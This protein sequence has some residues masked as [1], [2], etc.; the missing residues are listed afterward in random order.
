MKKIIFS[1]SAVLF[2]TALCAQPV[3]TLI[4]MTSEGGNGLGTIFGLSPGGV[5]LTQQYNFDGNTGKKPYAG[6]IQATNGKLYGMTGDGGI[7]NQ[8]IIF[9]YDLITQTYSKKYDFIYDMGGT[10]RGKLMQA[11]NGKLY[12]MTAGGGANGQGVLFEFDIITS[13]FIN[14]ADFNSATTGSNPL[15]SLIQASNGKLY[16]LANSGGINDKGVLFEYDITSNTLILKKSFN[17]TNGSY[18]YGSLM[19]AS[20]DKLYGMTSEGGVNNLGLLFE[21]DITG[22][23][24]TTKKSFN[25]TNGSHPLGSLIQANNNKLYG[26]TFDGGVSDGGAL[27]EYDFTANIFSVKKSFDGTNGA[28]PNGSLMQAPDG[29]LY[30]MTTYGGSSDQGVILQ[31]D[32]TG[33]VLAVVAL[34]ISNG[35]GGEPVG[36][37][38]QASNGKFYGATQI[39]LFAGQG[40]VFEYNNITGDYR[41]LIVFNQAPNGSVPNASLVQASNGKLYGLTKEGGT[42]D[43]GV[44]FEYN[45]A[46]NAY[47]KKIDFNGINGA[48]PLGSL[49]Q[50]SN[51]KLYGMATYG[52]AKSVG[53]IFEYNITTNILTKK[54]DFD[55][56]VTG[57]YP[58]GALMQASNGKLYGM[59]S[60]GGMNKKGVLF[61]YDITSNTCTKKIDFNGTNLGSNPYGSLLQSTNG[62]L[63]G[64]ATLGGNSDKGT[65]FEYDA[66]NNTYA[67]KMDFDGIATGSNPE[68]SLIQSSNGKLYG[69][70]NSGGINDKGVLFEYDETN[71]VFTKKLDFDSISTGSYPGGSLILASNGKLYGMT[72]GGGVNYGGVIFEYDLSTNSY[73]KKVDF[74]G[75]NGTYPKGN[76]IEISLCQSTYSIINISNC[77]SYT[78]N[79]QTYISSGIYTQTLPNSVGCDSVITLNLT[80]NNTSSTITQIACNSYTWNGNIYSTS[81]T[82]NDTIPNAAN[83]DSIM[84]L[85]LIIKQPSSSNNIISA[86]NNY[87]WNGTTYSASGTFNKTISNKAGCDSSMTLNLTINNASS[88]TT[89]QTAC[90]SYIWN[91]TTYIS[92][93]TYNK[94]IPNKAGC[95]SVM[96]LQ[97]TIKNTYSTQT[98]SACANYTWNGKVYT[99]SNTYKDTIPNAASCDSIMT[100]NLTINNAPA[101]PSTIAGS[102]T[103]C[104]GTTNTYSITAVAG[105]TNYTWTLPSGWSG[106]ST[107][108]SIS[109]TANTTGGS[110]TVIANNACGSS[111]ARTLAVTVNSITATPGT[112]NGNASICSGTANTYSVAAVAGATDYIWTL[113]SGWTGTSTTNSISTTASATS[114]YVTVKSNNACG[115]SSSKTLTITVNAINVSV[116]Q[117]NAI[118]T[119]NAT[120][121]FYQWLDCNNGNAIISGENS[122]TFIASANGSYAV[123][124]TKSGCS[125]TSS[126][127]TVDMGS[128]G[129]ANNSVNNLTV[130]P[131]PSTGLF[132]IESNILNGKL[133]ISNLLGVIVFEKDKFQTGENIDLSRIAE[134]VYYLRIQDKENQII[135][136]IVIHK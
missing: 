89:T 52:G 99:T 132:Y 39:D 60:E 109:T 45:P 87:T 91:G 86:C 19:Q 65:L 97:L 13:T 134:G 5:N 111:S 3:P 22:N 116:T 6:V 2:C 43:V 127:Y 47:S 28:F 117:N 36:E 53:V 66:T 68:G 4:G 26:L 102:A 100:L 82:F 33:N 21:Y 118:L 119:A 136:P 70:T 120:S 24:L 32:I 42:N 80:I 107:T 92:T 84:T 27:F 75:Q 93:G 62:K 57:S 105:A 1:I 18:P 10:P 72:I 56:T 51:G 59:T 114:G 126:C 69:L 37:L 48:Y 41:N 15:G 121:D 110:I 23:I 58:L 104:S 8:G 129:I 40:V 124:L 12:G 88:S 11:S 16:G 9:E 108:N 115:A 30:G 79:S 95:D 123:I 122:K 106:V 73:S 34:S 61:E 98:I 135:K 78:L 20:N 101:I 74:D 46:T 113:P 64:M 29:K 17:G 83:C 35:T 25:G 38:I 54:I 14:K 76:L 71:N 31:Y 133:I 44:L 85:N 128:V 96:T 55:S 50:A 49:I 63:Y 130:Y 7:Y 131:N 103:V 77:N 67:K 94:T 81:G 125:D 90:S 112:I